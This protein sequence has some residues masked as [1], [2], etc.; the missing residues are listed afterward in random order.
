MVRAET[1]REGGNNH[2]KYVETNRQRQDGET[3]RKEGG[4]DRGIEE[5]KEEE[6]K[7]TQRRIN[8]DTVVVAPLPT[9][10]H[11]NFSRFTRRK[12]EE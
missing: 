9:A 2:C 11:N 7:G 4:R 3:V 12:V 5:R 6:K 8:T 10:L 1:R